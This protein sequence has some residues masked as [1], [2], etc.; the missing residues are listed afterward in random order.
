MPVA[1]LYCEVYTSVAIIHTIIATGRDSSLI[2]YMRILIPNTG[3]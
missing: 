3:M 1:M 2:A